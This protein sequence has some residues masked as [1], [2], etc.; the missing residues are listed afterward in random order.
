MG[1]Q[2]D[3]ISFKYILCVFIIINSC[4]CKKQKVDEKSLVNQTNFHSDEFNQQKN[5]TVPVIFVIAHSSVKDEIVAVSE[6]V[7]SESA[8]YNTSNV[9]SKETNESCYEQISGYLYETDKVK[10]FNR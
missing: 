9:Y 4:S 7:K 6:Q 5:S 1:E 2:C 10:K 8:Y 3:S